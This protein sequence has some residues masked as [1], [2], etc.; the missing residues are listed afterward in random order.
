VKDLS[1]DRSPM[2]TRSPSLKRTAVFDQVLALRTFVRIVEAG[3]FAK[4]ADS[5]NMPRSSASK[6]LQ[7]LEAHLGTKLLERNTRS[8]TVTLEGVAYHERAIRLLSDLD[9]MDTLVTS[10]TAGPKGK[11]RVNIGSIL[12]NFILVP[13]L[14][15]FQQKYPDIEILLGISDRMVDIVSEGV[16][17]VIRGGSLADTTLVAKRLCELDYVTCAAPSY[18]KSRHVPTSPLEIQGKHRV[19]SYFSALSGKTFPLRFA[20]MDEV[21][22]FVSESGIALNESTAHLNSLIAGL[23]VGQTFKFIARPYLQSGALTQI[24]ADWTQPPHT[25]H[26]VW[27]ASR[28]PSLK[29]RVF[30]EWVHGVFGEYDARR[31]R[32]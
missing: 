19:V 16:D 26:L 6:L 8:V 2:G 32:A 1:L 30:T 15:E 17:C 18:L 13:R 24:L 23:G 5:L 7:D 29:L 11:L 9:E 3:S 22:E 20:K 21:I 27:P 31:V 28:F 10:S 12:A 25:L 4:A 14:A